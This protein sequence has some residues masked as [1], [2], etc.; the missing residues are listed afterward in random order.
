MIESK[1][2]KQ[3]LAIAGRGYESNIDLI[4]QLERKV[5]E[6][7]PD[8]EIFTIGKIELI[9]SCIVKSAFIASVNIHYD[10][11]TGTGYGFSTPAFLFVKPNQLCL[12]VNLPFES[13]AQISLEDMLFTMAI[14]VKA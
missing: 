6:T 11:K 5:V 14:N 4:T 9:D 12:T 7:N 3:L 13:D 10:D 1:M 8:P 2:I